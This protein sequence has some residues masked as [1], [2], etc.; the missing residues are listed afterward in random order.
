MGTRS[1]N[2]PAARRRPKTVHESRPDPRHP[3]LWRSRNNGNGTDT[4]CA[5]TGTGIDV[6]SNISYGAGNT[7]TIGSTSTIATGTQSTYLTLNNAGTKLFAGINNAYFTVNT[8]DNTFTTTALSGLRDD[9]LYP[10][11]EHITR[12]GRHRHVAVRPSPWPGSPR[13]VIDL[14]K[15]DR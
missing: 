13:A 12:Q 6:L 3:E 11:P 10:E 9:A 5:A 1:E 4:V 7:L 8:S 2:S 14:A 15:S